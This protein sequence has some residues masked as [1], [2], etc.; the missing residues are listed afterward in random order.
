MRSHSRRGSKRKNSWPW[1]PLRRNPQSS[2]WGAR[3]SRR[4]DVKGLSI[5]EALDFVVRPG[6]GVQ[7]RVN[8]RQIRVGNLALAREGLGKDL[9]LVES[10]LAA[11]SRTGQTAVIVMADEVPLGIVALRDP[12]GQASR[13]PPAARSGRSF[14]GCGKRAR[15]EEHPDQ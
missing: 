14:Q 9:S 6:M 10:M 12:L 3:L 4:R 15:G 11:H 13:C 1:L 2:F 7:A 8:G 5:P